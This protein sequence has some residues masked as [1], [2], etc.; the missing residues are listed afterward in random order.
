[1]A[2]LRGHGW[3]IMALRIVSV[4][5]LVVAVCTALFT[6]RYDAIQLSIDNLYFSIFFVLCVAVTTVLTFLVFPPFAK[7]KG[8][9]AQPKKAAVLSAEPEAAPEEEPPRRPNPFSPGFGGRK[10]PPARE[11]KAPPL[12][13]GQAWPQEKRVRPARYPI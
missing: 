9:L 2:Y 12:G 5:E 6:Y 4:V 3:D 1:M 10:A 13:Q 11:E 7:K 8:L